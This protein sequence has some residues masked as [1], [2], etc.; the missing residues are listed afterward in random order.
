VHQ[1]HCSTYVRNPRCI[2][3]LTLFV[4]VAVAMPTQ[5]QTYT[6]LHDFTDSPDGAVPNPIIQDGKGNFYGS[7]RFGGIADCDLDTCGTVFKIDSAGNESILY[8]FQGGNNGV[9]PIGSLALDPK[10]NLWGVTQGNGF[11]D[12][13]SAVF[14][15]ESNGHETSYDVNDVTIC[16]LDS[17]LVAD[18]K[19]N[20]YGMSPYGGRPMCPYVKN[21][22]GCGTLFEV[23]PSGKFKVLHTFTG[24]D[25][26]QPEGGLVIDANGN[27][28]GSA[29]Y[30]GKLKCSYPGWGEPIGKGCGTIYKLD[31]QGDFTVLHS[32]TGPNDGSYPL[33][34]TIDSAGNL[35]GIAG[36][37]GDV[38][39]NSNYEYGLGTIFKVD[40]E[41]KFKV[42]FTFTP[43][44]TLNYVYASHLAIDSHGNLYGMQ[45][46]N[47]CAGAGCLFKIDTQGN[48]TDIYNFDDA[49]TSGGVFITGIT[50]G[51]LLASDGTIYGTTPVGGDS[52]GGGECSESCGT[53]YKLVLSTDASVAV[54]TR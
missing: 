12:G 3:L 7:T 43:E 4:V 26:I 14:K 16:C 51:L 27:L 18:A 32:F 35:Y 53:V 6:V 40:A 29:F 54:D 11:D 15:L 45:E 9:T 20:L 23:S 33:G 30:G 41:G 8:D 2:V 34:L 48:Y 5:A 42:L 22:L 37:G 17:P 52:N 50:P 49:Q 39:P 31:T 46:A 38:I 10:G 24:T 36:S 47:N 21:N 1:E 19:G 25:G 28:Y 13:A 44:T